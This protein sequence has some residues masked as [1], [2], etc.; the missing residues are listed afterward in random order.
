[1]CLPAAQDGGQT[2]PPPEDSEPDRKAVLSRN[3]R[4]FGVKAKDPTKECFGRAD[5]CIGWSH[6]KT[7]VRVVGKQNVS[8][9]STCQL[10]VAKEGRCNILISSDDASDIWRGG[11][12]EKK[13]WGRTLYQWC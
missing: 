11:N 4:M 1:M 7:S 6:T 13:S 3:S 9:R 12:A 5:E 10:P 8:F 2:E